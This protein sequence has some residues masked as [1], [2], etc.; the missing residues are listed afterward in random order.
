MAAYFNRNIRILFRAL[1]KKLGKKLDFDWLAMKSGFPSIQLQ[2]WMRDGEPNLAQGRKLAEFFSKYLETE[3][4]VELILM[5]DIRT[6]SRF[7]SF[8]WKS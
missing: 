4:T 2:G 1:E 5:R 8:A 6:D 7:L 3:V